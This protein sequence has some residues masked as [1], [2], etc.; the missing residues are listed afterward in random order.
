MTALSFRRLARI[1]KD[2]RG[3][4]VLEGAIILPLLLVLT[5]GII[6]FAAL[7]YVDLTLQNGVSQASRFGV[8]GNLAPGMSREES[9]RAAFRN[10]TPTLSVD[11][12]AFEF[13]HMSPGGSS[14][15]SGTGGPNDIEKVTINYSWRI[16]TPV[17]RPFFPGGQFNFRVE[18]AMKNE[19]RFE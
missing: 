18:A 16:L 8:T 11:D 14:W 12:S 10:A 9:I 1:V 19:G 3:V 17:I 4:N 5:F 13:A 6:D 2:T 7:F 15:S